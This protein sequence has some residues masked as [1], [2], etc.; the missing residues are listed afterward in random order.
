MVIGA[1][2]VLEFVL[3]LYRLSRRLQY[4]SRKRL[5]LCTKI[6]GVTPTRQCS[7]EPILWGEFLVSKH[8]KIFLFRNTGDGAR[9]YT[10][11][12]YNSNEGLKV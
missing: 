7:S 11:R 10:T 8:S 12:Y 2:Y 1:S 9:V 3:V 5:S 6:Q 4:V